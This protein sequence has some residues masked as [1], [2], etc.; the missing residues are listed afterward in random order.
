MRFLLLTFVSCFLLGSETPQ[1]GV[2]SVIM[3]GP[4]SGSAPLNPCLVAAYPMNEGSGLTL[5]D[6]TA[7]HNTATLAATGHTWQSNSGLPG[8]TVLFTGGGGVNG[9]QAAS[10]TPTSFTN[11]QPFSVSFWTTNLTGSPPQFWLSNRNGA[12]GLQGWTI[13]RTTGHVFQFGVLGTSGT[14]A[15]DIQSAAAVGVVGLHMG[16]V[17]YDG[18]GLAS[19]ANLYWD[20]LHL[21]AN[22]NR[23]NLATSSASTIPLNF[24]QESGSGANQLLGAMGFVEVYNC[25]ITSGFV[26]SSFAG[27]P[28]IY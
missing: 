19:G 1:I 4:P 21:T 28:G 27:G 6:T 24:G 18:S 8:T 3:T 9:A 20:G 14:N 26:A 22:T 23:N 15:V 13:L 5:N 7:T 17:S 16:A 2:Q 10:A 25:V 12:T 11:T